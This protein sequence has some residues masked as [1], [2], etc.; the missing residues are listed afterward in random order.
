[1]S[2]KFSQWIIWKSNKNIKYYD[3]MQLTEYFTLKQ[4]FYIVANKQI[5]LPASYKKQYMIKLY[6]H[7]LQWFIYYILM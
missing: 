4:L 6:T 2:T 5:I 1:M 7:G 3:V